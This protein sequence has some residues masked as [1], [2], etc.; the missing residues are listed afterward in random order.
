MTFSEILLDWY[1]KNARQLP[2]R[3]TKDPYRV[4]V[5]EII[6]QQTRVDQGLPYY[7]R[8]I[9]HFPKVTDLHQASED[10]VLRLW[11]GL[12]YYSR[13]RNMKEAARQIEEDFNGKFPHSYQEILSLKGIG[14]Y[15]AAAISSI[16]FGES[17]AVVDGNVYRV[18]SRYLNIDTPINSTDGQKQFAKLAN[19]MILKKHP[20]DY[21]QAIM[22]FGARMC[23]PVNPDCPNCPLNNGCAAYEAG[24]VAEL[25]VKLKKLK[26][27]NQF[28]HFFYITNGAQFLIEKRGLQSIW[29]GLYQLPLIE[30]K[31]K[32][33]LTSVLET[34]D[35]RKIIS[36][37]SFELVEHTEIKH[38]L[39]HRNLWIR[40]YHLKIGDLNGL[41]Y[42]KIEFNDWHRYAFPKPI[43]EFL[44]RKEITN[45]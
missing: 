7:L 37:Q 36:D 30:T 2:W 17:T 33:D 13:A 44:S 35:L 34:T 4:W 24:R 26:I 16:C 40:F 31:A 23:V 28:L 14:P 42:E 39:T 10:Q 8:F 45:L 12:G 21:N 15:T 9:E 29:K 38:K 27:K 43:V 20:G 6:L 32:K 41:K 22:E 11:Q 3:E 18:L 25:P 1:L 5:S 19:T